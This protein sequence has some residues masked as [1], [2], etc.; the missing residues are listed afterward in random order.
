MGLDVSGI[1]MNPLEQQE[2]KDFIIERVYE[3]PAVQMVHGA[4]K[5]GINVK[6]QIAFA[7]QFGKTGLKG[8][9]SCD[10][11]TSNPQSVLTEKFWDPKIIEDT[12]IVCQRDL[13]PLFKAYY[14]KIRRYREIYDITGSDLEI[15][16]AIMMVESMVRT[17]W[18]AAWY[19]D[20]AVAAAGAGTAGLV[21]SNDVK[22]YDYFDGLWKQIFTAVGATTL[23]RVTITENA[24]TTSKA[25]QLALTDG[26]SVAYFK[27]IWEVADVRLR[28]NPD[29][30][31][32]VSREIFD[33]YISYLEDNSLN[34]TI[35]VV[36]DGL[37]TVK[38]RGVDVI[39]METVFGLEHREDFVNN[40]TDNVYDNP[41][42]IVFSV[43]DNLPIGTLS[44]DDFDELE[45][46]YDRDSR[47]N[48]T[49]YGFTEDSK[50][51]E[52]YMAIV[53]Y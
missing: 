37:Q 6:E 30:K 43:P 23:N 34:Y 33:N 18:R 1:T 19:A 12:L 17:I 52:E 31:M 41:H 11:Q 15:F 20:T 25:N 24:V 32:F 46:W 38:W 3:N 5:Q 42:R 14:T 51:L 53:A 39:N 36:Q 9:S 47:T 48:K 28:S 27:S 22:F 50:L 8:N 10:R 4:I 40:T 13:D 44:Q 7:G 16:Y 29:A 26:K 49:A 21:D 2:I 35:D 45:Q